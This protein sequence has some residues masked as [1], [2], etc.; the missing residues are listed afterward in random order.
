M[1]LL[2][3]MRDAGPTTVGPMGLTE[4]LLWFLF[5]SLVVFLIYHGLRVESVGEAASRGFRKW[6]TFLM[7][8]AL[9]AAVSGL[10]AE[11]L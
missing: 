9:L 8:T 3:A 10:L 5:L 7:G 1:T 6:V 2:A 4:H 11:V